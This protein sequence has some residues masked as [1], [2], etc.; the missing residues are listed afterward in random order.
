MRVSYFT[1]MTESLAGFFRKTSRASSCT[2]LGSRTCGKKAPLTDRKW[3][4]RW[5]I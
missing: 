2:P 1:I 4:C 3:D 5:K